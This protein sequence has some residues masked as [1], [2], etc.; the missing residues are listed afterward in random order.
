MHPTQSLKLELILI[1][2]PELDIALHAC[3]ALGV[4]ARRVR[5]AS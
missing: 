3:Q 5:A 2:R 4:C 1:S